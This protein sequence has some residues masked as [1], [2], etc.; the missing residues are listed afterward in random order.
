MD[1]RNDVSQIYQI[2]P[3]HL[4]QATFLQTE[5]DN[6]PSVHPL[7]TLITSSPGVQA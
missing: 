6:S 2:C 3:V 5:R 1:E 4:M 7:Q